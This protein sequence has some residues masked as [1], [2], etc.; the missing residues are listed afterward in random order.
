MLLTFEQPETASWCPFKIFLLFMSRISWSRQHLLSTPLQLNVINIIIFLLITSAYHLQLS[1][2][3]FGYLPLYLHL[4]W[5]VTSVLTEQNSH[6]SHCHRYGCD[7]RKQC[8]HSECC[9][10]ILSTSS[11]KN[12]QN[13]ALGVILDLELSIFP[14]EL[15][16]YPLLNPSVPM[17][18]SSL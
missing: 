17:R 2:S 1:H 14:S 9:L 18:H 5:L 4:K 12:V 13:S 15:G 16:D 11:Q 10:R 6:Q 8:H 7:T 3:S